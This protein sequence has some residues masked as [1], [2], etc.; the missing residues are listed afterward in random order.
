MLRSPAPQSEK[1]MSLEKT[2]AK[3]NNQNHGSSIESI[4]R[5]MALQRNSFA[6]IDVVLRNGD[7]KA[8]CDVIGCLFSMFFCLASNYQPRKYHQAKFL[9][10]TLPIDLSTTTSIKIQNKF[11]RELIANYS[12]ISTLVIYCIKIASRFTM[13]LSSNR[14]MLWQSTLQF[15]AQSIEAREYC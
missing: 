12:R 1:D 11:V 9:V 3:K 7:L 4:K 14:L 13:K 15:L 8:H 10:D 2:I 6:L 5:Y